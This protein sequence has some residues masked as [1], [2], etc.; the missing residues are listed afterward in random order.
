MADTQKLRNPATPVR[1]GLVGFGT[2]G[3]GVYKNLERNHELL[4]ER[5]G[6]RL[7][8][9]K[10]VLRDLEK[11]R[12]PAP[13]ADIVSTDWHDIV[14]DPDIDIVVELIGGTGTA[15]DLVEA[16][17]AAG[18]IV[19]T[20]NKA[21]LAEHGIELMELAEKGNVPLYCEAAVA[22]GI[23]IIKVVGEALVGN[24]IESIHGIIN[25][26]SNYILTR[27]ADEGISY[28]EAL[29]AA[30]ALGYAE[31]DP[32]LDVNG[33]DAAH[34]ALVLAWL[35]YG[36]WLR[37]EEI[38]VEG[39]ENVDLEDVAFARSLG[40]EIKLVSVIRPHPSGAVELRTEPSLLP[41]S[42]ILASVNGVFN[43]LVVRG[44]VVGETLYYGSG[45]GQDA[46]SS[47]VISDLADAASNLATKA[48]YSGFLPRGEHG[49]VVPL[50]ETVS[51][52]Y[53]RLTVDDRPGVVASI[54]GIL[55]DSGIGILSVVQPRPEEDGVACLVFMLH[56]AS[57]GNV[58][59]ALAS[60]A[61]QD[62][63]QGE[64]VLYRVEDL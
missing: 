23:P 38:H 51:Q 17:L 56:D 14:E 7:E 58:Q 18:K 10:I 35:S 2:V 29:A 43:A 55:A 53:L 4:T 19:V 59:T 52:Y 62:C 42:H 48:G 33:W 25:G 44:D 64:P 20:G 16:A 49:T 39:I 40:Y 9:T 21:L 15:K 28:D 36:S 5:T 31:T 46:T 50:D 41:A 63:V 34:K 45:A 8:V 47:S 61:K 60:M 13:P 1:I 3:A 54:S 27:M 6:A 32:T 12:D 26:T 11:E 37:P 57:W 30:Q 22:G 24:R